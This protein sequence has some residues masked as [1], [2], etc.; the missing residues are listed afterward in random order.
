[1]A[2]KLGKILSDFTTQL[3]AKIAV[4]GTTGTLQSN[5]DDDGIT[6]PDGQFYFTLDG[7][8]SQKEHI[9]C[10][11]TGTALTAIYSVSR[12]GALA[13]GVVREHRV[14]CSVVITDFLHIKAMNDL[15]NGTDSFNAAVPLGYDGT[16]SITTANQLA[17]KAY[18]DGVAI[19]GA[20]DASATVKGITKL[21]TA[22]VSPTIPIAVGDN[23]NRVSPVSLAAVTAG[24]VAALV[25]SETSIAVGSG[26]TFVTETG[27]QNRLGITVSI[28][29][30]TANAIAMNLTPAP[31]AY[32]AGQQFQ[33]AL[34]VSITGAA[35]L[36][37]NSLG[38]KAIKKNGS[39]ALV[40][41]D[42]AANQYYQ[43]IYDGSVFQLL[44]PT[45]NT[46]TSIPA[47]KCGTTTKNAADASTIQTIAHGLGVIPKYVRIT[48]LATSGVSYWPTAIAV[49]N[50]TTNAGI[51]TVNNGS[52]TA[53]QQFDLTVSGTAG[54]QTGT[55][56]FDATNISINWTKSGGPTGSY[57]LLWEAFS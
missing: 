50:G 28:G 57:V 15:L 8:N 11:K 32:Q 33:F 35:T 19:A 14:G 38:A 52:G 45:A 22:P 30:N 5:T 7:N 40:S 36:N 24:K 12:Q 6:L 23:D 27:L 46:P 29:I 25:G 37:V 21:S 10:Q 48:A 49:Y 53:E 9:Q 1:M 31:V 47:F 56:S 18:V 20:P 55:L 41:G 16:A 42:L 44:S 39:L 54:S 51:A 2:S 26:N 43:V 34:D 3:A 17:T 4:G 13:S